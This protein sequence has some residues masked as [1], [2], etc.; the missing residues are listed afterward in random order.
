L[1]IIKEAATFDKSKPFYFSQSDN[2][3]K[4]N[5]LTSSASWAEL[6]HDTILYVKQSYGEKAG[7]G[8]GPTWVIDR[9]KRP[10]SYVEPNLGVLYWLESIL[11]DSDE[12]LAKNGIMSEQ[13]RFK[14]EDYLSIINNLVKIAEKESN[15]NSI[16][17]DENNFIYSVP[18]KISAIISPTE[19][20]VANDKEL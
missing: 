8:P 2:W 18:D 10:I 13:Y 12:I 3:N 9:V 11:N 4:K 16:S 5:L 20:R 19:G 15:D 1:R 14:F 6:R 17:E 7:K